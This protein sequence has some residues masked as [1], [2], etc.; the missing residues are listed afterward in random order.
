MKNLNRRSLLSA[1]GVA[2]PFGIGTQVKASATPP[3]PSLR[4]ISFEEA[5]RYAFSDRFSAGVQSCDCRRIEVG[6][7][8]TVQGGVQGCYNDRPFAG[9]PAGYLRI[10]RTGSEPGHVRQGVRLYISTVDVILTGGLQRD[11]PSRPLDFASL[12]AAPSFS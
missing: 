4:L 5:V 3:A 7:S 8:E 6:H 10:V 12:P 2:L 1:F 11:V 9:F